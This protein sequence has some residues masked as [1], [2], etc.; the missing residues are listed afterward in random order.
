MLRCNQSIYYLNSARIH[1]RRT[2]RRHSCA[3]RQ[4]IVAMIHEMGLRIKNAARTSWLSVARLSCGIRAAGYAGRGTGFGLPVVVWID[5]GFVISDLGSISLRNGFLILLKRILDRIYQSS[6][7][8]RLG[9]QD[10]LDFY[11]FF[12]FSGWKLTKELHPAA[13]IISPNDS[14]LPRISFVVWN[15]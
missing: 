12:S 6:L 11:H 3:G 8:L 1:Q 9:K 7:K 13:F 5:F 10:Y 4:Q 2:S 14:P 15:R